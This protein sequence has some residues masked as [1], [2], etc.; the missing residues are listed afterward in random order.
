MAN[1]LAGKVA[2]I[3]GGSQG[4]GLAIAQRFAQEGADVAF[5]YRSNKAGAE[6]VAA[7]IRKLGRKTV[8]FQC[9]V[10]C[11]ADGQKF[12]ADAV[13]Q[14]GRIDILVN[15]AGLERRA[16]FWDATEADYDDVLNVNLKGVFLGCK[17]G[18]PAL[19]R[20]GGGSVINTA[21]FVAVLGAATPQ[22]AYTASKGGVLALSRELAIVPGPH[23]FIAAVAF[24]P[25]RQWVVSGG[26]TGYPIIQHYCKIL[27][28]QE[29]RTA[30]P[31]RSISRCV[32]PT[33][34]T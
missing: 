11:V 28:Y 23:D 31:L 8:G 20:A 32:S 34:A 5:C 12:I 25:D 17:Y 2:A 26:L 15:N 19:R 10:G 30:R 13:T 14:F 27:Y 18:I 24:S 16:D 21:S 9:D 3:T 1:R 6:Q 4:I 7:E 22:I 33:P 29:I